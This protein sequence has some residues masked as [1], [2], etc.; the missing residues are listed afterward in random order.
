MEDK[1]RKYI[2][3]NR[4]SFDELEPDE[5]MWQAISREIPGKKQGF[6]WN[7]W[8]SRAA[9]ILLAMGIGFWIAKQGNQGGNTSDEIAMQQLPQEL[10]DAEGYYHRLINLRMGEIKALDLENG[11][12][13]DIAADIEQLDTMYEEL[14]KKL[15]LQVNQ[16]QITDAMIQNLQMRIEILNRQLEIL[17]KAKNSKKQIEYEA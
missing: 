5:E 2:Q 8:L 13:E 16:E 11:Y 15:N 12:Y 7:M 4:E 6:A 17:E 10:Q 1:L 9:I 3:Q 14:K